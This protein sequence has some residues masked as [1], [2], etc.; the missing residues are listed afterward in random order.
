MFLGCGWSYEDALDTC[1]DK[2]RDDTPF[3][4]EETVVVTEARGV[5][6]RAPLRDSQRHKHGVNKE[7]GGAVSRRRA[8]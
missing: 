2:G 3:V 4:V 8:P 1:R 6:V 5:Q 7:G